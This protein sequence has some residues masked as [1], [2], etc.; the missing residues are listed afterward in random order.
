MTFS[1][2]SRGKALAT[3][4]FDIESYLTPDELI[5]KIGR[6]RKWEIYVTDKRVIFKPAHEGRD[7]T[8]IVATSHHRI[9]SVEYKK[10]DPSRY[11]A[12]GVVFVGF[13]IVLPIL[14]NEIFPFVFTH[15]PTEATIFSILITMSTALIGII[16]VG[17][18]LFAK[19]NLTVHVRGKK[20]LTVS[21]E[22]EEI[23][24][25]IDK[26]RKRA[27]AER[28]HSTKKPKKTRRRSPKKN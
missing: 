10:K 18:S 17:V 24:E 19:P 11:I 12:V 26:N 13:A 8:E 3:L 23:V 20:L 28:R 22:L 7:G 1:H 15:Y 14:L 16:L 21:G 25:A 6:S 5:V 4:P 27:K 2:V 9:S